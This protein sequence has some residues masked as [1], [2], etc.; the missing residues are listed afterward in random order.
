MRDSLYVIAGG[1]G[2]LGI[3]LASYLV[4][5]G[6]G[7]KILSRKAPVEG[8]WQHVRWDGHTLDGWADCLNEADG[9]VNLA[10][11]TVDCIKS[12]DH[13][14]EILR[15]RVDSTRVLGLALRQVDAPPGV[16]VQMGTAHIYG[17]P[18]VQRCTEESSFGHGLAPFV[19]RA[20]EAAFF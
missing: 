1:S 18:P 6:A 4:E 9:L 3:S 20:W 5:Q 17:D 10:G 16:W 14:D 7:V 19:A 15:S 12:P 8:P 13:Q 2:F 11:R